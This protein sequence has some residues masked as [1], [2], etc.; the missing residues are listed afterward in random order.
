MTTTTLCIKKNKAF[1]TNEQNVIQKS[2][3]Q[4][5][6]FFFFFFENLVCISVDILTLFFGQYKIKIF[7]FF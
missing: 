1:L 5:V 4:N 2:E 6:I 3:R 7:V